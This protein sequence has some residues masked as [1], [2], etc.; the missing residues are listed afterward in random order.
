MSKFN[1][2]M[3]FTDQITKSINLITIMHDILAIYAFQ[4]YF[5]QITSAKYVLCTQTDKKDKKKVKTAI[6]VNVWTNGN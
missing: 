4:K 2:L 5:G 6:D 3:Y 1:D